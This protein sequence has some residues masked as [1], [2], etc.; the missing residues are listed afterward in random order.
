MKS[1]KFNFA[2][3]DL[4]P[5]L[6]TNLRL[7]L[8]NELVQPLSANHLIFH[9]TRTEIEISIFHM[10]NADLT[11]SQ[12]SASA[13]R[14]IRETED[15]G[16]RG[17]TRNGR[18]V[19]FLVSREVMESILETMELQKNSTLMKLVRDFKAGKV[20]FTKVPDED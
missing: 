13:P 14:A 7:H 20:K 1:S 9:L 19:A 8:Q 2:P 5:M 10:K 17:I 18:A 6:F 3:T 4:Q 11:I 15:Y 12:L 16:V